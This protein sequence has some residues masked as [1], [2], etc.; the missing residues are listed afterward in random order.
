LASVADRTAI[1][2]VVEIHH[3]DA[4]VAHDTV[5]ALP[6]IGPDDFAVQWWEG[7]YFKSPL[8]DDARSSFWDEAEFVVSYS[9]AAR[10]ARWQLTV[11]LATD[12]H[13]EYTSGQV[14]RLDGQN[15]RLLAGST[16]P[17]QAEES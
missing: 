13:G 16:A 12:D 15:S 10:S 17:V 2:V 5:E 14:R 6:G 11:S 7:C 3:R 9:D 1:D 8:D 4:T